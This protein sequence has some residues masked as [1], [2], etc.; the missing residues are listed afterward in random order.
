MFYKLE[1][2]RGLAACAL[3]LFHSP[4][5]FEGMPLALIRN[6]YL[7]V[8]LFF[9][10]SGFVMTHAYR[11]KIAQGLPFKEYLMLR[12]GRIYPL[13]LVMLLAF[14]PY[15]FV[16]GH[17]MHHDFAVSDPAGNSHF[18]TF[19]T[20]LLLIQAW[21]IDAGLSWNGP[22]WS[23]STEF[24]VYILF[25]FWMRMGA[26]NKSLVAAL[27]ISCGAYLTLFLV[28]PLR[29][30]FT[31]DF[32][33]LRCVAGFSLGVC[34][35]HLRCK[36]GPALRALPVLECVSMGLSVWA[37]MMAD[38]NEFALHGTSLAFGFLVFVC[39]DAS[40]GP[41]GRLLALPA[42]RHLG[43]W[44]YSI[45][46][47]HA[48]VILLCAN[49]I[50]FFF[51]LDTTR[52]LGWYAVLLN[53]VV[54]STVVAIACFSYRWIECPGRDWARR[55]FHSKVNDAIPIVAMPPRS[56]Y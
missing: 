50:H 56:G 3:V 47:I 49:V 55:R 33:V 2:L 44:S 21:H 41:I 28:D 30:D 4:Y 43:L 48:M 36:V 14:V 52:A 54:F 10:L 27:L 35:Y 40:D 11:A 53:T 5:N 26:R 31:S 45:Y 15:V 34:V 19:L 17:L 16:K 13:H 7:F 25:F 37:V 29:L 38:S 22:S 9:V 12:L 18:N 51:H 39:S 46:M 1:A 8:D 32:G 23:I 20:N 6:A 24:A 42:V